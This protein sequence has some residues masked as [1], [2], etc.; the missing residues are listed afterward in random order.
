MKKILLVCFFSGIMASV[1]LAQDLPINPWANST[2]NTVKITNSSQS[3]KE[4]MTKRQPSAMEIWAEKR[5]A[6]VRKAQQENQQR[7]LARQKAQAEQLKAMAGQSSSGGDDGGIL[8]EIGNLFSDDSS[9][10][11]AAPAK[12]QSSSDGDFMKEYNDLM[13]SYEK[14]KKDAEQSV[15]KAKRSVKGLTNLN[16]IEKSIDDTLKSLK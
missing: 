10:P 4:K 1:S 16:N 9:K 15:N 14:M 3:T 8:D 13:N 12:Q 11:A 5:S 6:E 7:A 2:N